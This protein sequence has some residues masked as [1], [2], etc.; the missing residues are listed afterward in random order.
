LLLLSP[1]VIF[2]SKTHMSCRAG[3]CG[4]G[5]FLESRLWDR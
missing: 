4:A 1:I 5:R 2:P 3:A